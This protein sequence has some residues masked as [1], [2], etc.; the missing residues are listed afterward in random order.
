M[1]K[2]ISHLLLPLAALAAM[3][4]TSCQQF[5]QNEGDKKTDINVSFTTGKSP[6]TR[7][8][9]EPEAVP[10]TILPL[11]M[12][13]ENAREISVSTS[14][15]LMMEDGTLEME[16]AELEQG[17]VTRG[18]PVYT[19]NL[20]SFTAS[21]YETLTSGTYTSKYLADATFEKDGSVW[22]HKYDGTKEWPSS[23]LRFFL[24]YPAGSASEG[25]T[26][27]T[28]SGKNVIRKTGYTTPGA[29]SGTTAAASQTD[30][31]FAT[32]NVTESSK[33]TP[34]GILFYHPFAGVKFKVGTMPEGMTITSVK[35]SN[36]YSKGD[37][38]ITPYYGN[39]SSY[40]GSGNNATGGDATKSE[41]CTVW[42]SLSNKTSF[43]QAFAAGEQ[44]GASLTEDLF[45]EGFADQGTTS[46]PNQNQLNDG[47]LSKTFILIPQAF[48]DSNKLKITIN[49]LYNSIPVTREVEIKATWQAG[50]LYTYT[51]NF[52]SLPDITI[53]D[54]VDGDVKKNVVITN[55]GNIPE[56]IR[57]AIIGNWFNADGQVVASWDE[58]QGTFTGLDDGNWTKDGDYH[59]YTEPVAPGE[60]TPEALFTTY[61]PPTAPVVGAHFEMLL[62][63]QSVIADKTVAASAWG[64][65]L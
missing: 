45:P 53:E 14:F 19:E 47:S 65:S 40:S 34:V 46:K 5:D 61:T 21:A 20:G 44:G 52:D 9:I 16:P 6:E 32:E 10:A 13:V 11:E 27:A 36:V 31:V 2:A 15:S 56:Y 54:E 7:S 30:I 62:V 25:W 38:T 39:G 50:H 43:E 8:A 1:N 41:S 59:Y 23:G 26:Y 17:P 60:A 4:L 37:C 28:E 24:R 18:T 22:S 35:L 49:L 58:T 55:T 42:S 64:V 57:V 29:G 48:G 51:I 33:D 3:E 63:V 12:E